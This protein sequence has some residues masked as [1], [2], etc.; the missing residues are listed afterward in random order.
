[1]NYS[2]R[3]AKVEETLYNRDGDFNEGGILYAWL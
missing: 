2:F 3:I 1:M